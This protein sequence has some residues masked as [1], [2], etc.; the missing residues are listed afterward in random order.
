MKTIYLVYGNMED[1]E[2]SSICE[3]KE[4]ALQLLIDNNIGDLIPVEI[5]EEDWSAILAVA[6]KQFKKE[7]V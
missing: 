5:T 2:P 7:A 6:W 3:Y 1:E 4:D